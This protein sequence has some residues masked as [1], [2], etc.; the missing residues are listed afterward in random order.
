[1]VQ[2]V[3]LFR[4]LFGMKTTHPF[5]DTFRKRGVLIILHVLYLSLIVF[6]V[7]GASRNRS[8]MPLSYDLDQDIILNSESITDQSST[9]V[10]VVN[11][12]KASI[13]RAI[14]FFSGANQRAESQPN[15]LSLQTPLIR[16]HELAVHRLV[17]F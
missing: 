14:D 2:K 7:I 12:E 15:S 10:H 13:G 4:F 8:P 1:M 5:F 3:E 11:D 16:H 9:G 17:F 6:A